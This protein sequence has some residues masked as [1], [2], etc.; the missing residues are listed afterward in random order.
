MA[1]LPVRRFIVFH[2]IGFQPVADFK[3]WVVHGKTKGL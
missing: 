2:F 3:F 1:F